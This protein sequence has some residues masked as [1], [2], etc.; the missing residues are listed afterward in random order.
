MN[1]NSVCIYVCG[2][3]LKRSFFPQH[4]SP[5]VHKFKIEHFIDPKKINITN[6]MTKPLLEQLQLRV[7]SGTPQTISPQAPWSL[8]TFCP[9]LVETKV[10]NP[11]PQKRTIEPKEE[12][13]KKVKDD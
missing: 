13:N 6:I 2:L 3:F 9:H 4:L 11:N 12:R 1:D 10:E 7:A 8:S 5:V